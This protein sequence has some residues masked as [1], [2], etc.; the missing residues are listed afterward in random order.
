VEIYCKDNNMLNNAIYLAQQLGIETEKGV[1]LT[2]K[3][4]PPQF[5]QKGLIEYPRIT[6]K[7]KMHLDIFVKYDKERYITLAHEMVHVR[8]VIRD[9][10]I[11]ENE[12]YILEKTLKTLDND[13]L[14]VVY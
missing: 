11:D 2:I 10:F 14:K 5:I 12:A 7:Q 6:S 9:K 1:E 3:R 8:Q 4:L 13:L